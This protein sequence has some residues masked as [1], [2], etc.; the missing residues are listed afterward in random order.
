MSFK[1]TVA[2]AAIVG[3]LGFSLDSPTGAD[4]AV[5]VD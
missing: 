4:C 2:R 1:K 5:A 3:A